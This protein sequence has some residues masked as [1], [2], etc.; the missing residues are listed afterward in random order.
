MKK[1]GKVRGS[2]DDT[3]EIS[4]EDVY[5]MECEG[6][7]ECFFK[8]KPQEKKKRK[9]EKREDAMFLYLCIKPIHN[10]SS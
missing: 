7:E 1:G 3:G 10:R 2:G 5:E 6:C 9:G 8:T 4:D